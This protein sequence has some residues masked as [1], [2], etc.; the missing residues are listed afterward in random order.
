METTPV[1][2]LTEE[3]IRL[4][5][6]VVKD[7]SSGAG[8]YHDMCYGP[9][10]V[11]AQACAAH[12][13]RHRYVDVYVEIA[14]RELDDIGRQL[15]LSTRFVHPLTLDRA[16]SDEVRRE[17]LVLLRERALAYEC[18]VGDAVVLACATW[19]EVCLWS[20]WQPPLGPAI[21]VIAR[22]EQRREEY[23]DEGVVGCAHT[24]QRCVTL[25]E[26]KERV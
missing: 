7:D 3:S 10:L 21:R 24:T 23:N 13:L 1:L 14:V 12:N 19:L 11:D 20:M 4:M 8:P 15:S 25:F 5:R 17:K 6:C 2:R 22:I 18:L 16:L 26:R 9:E